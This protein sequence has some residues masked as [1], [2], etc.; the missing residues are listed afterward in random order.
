[1]TNRFDIEGSV[2]VRKKRRRKYIRIVC[3]WYGSCVR[4]HVHVTCDSIHGVGFWQFY[5]HQNCKL[6]FIISS[7]FLF[8]YFFHKLLFFLSSKCSQFYSKHRIRE[9]LSESNI[10]LV[11]ADVTLYFDVIT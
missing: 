2:F 10:M 5:Y 1:M 7:N 3:V 8:Y 4:N 9:K 6:K 11:T